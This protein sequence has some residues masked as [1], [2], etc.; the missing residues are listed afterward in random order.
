MIRK[1][2][3]E[4]LSRTLRKMANSIVRMPMA[5]V[6]IPVLIKILSVPMASATMAATPPG[7]VTI[8]S[9]SGKGFELGF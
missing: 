5:D 1:T 8:P 2:L 9:D 3:M 7:A 6:G 4:K